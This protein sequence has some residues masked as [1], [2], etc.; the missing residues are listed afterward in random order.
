MTSAAPQ[1][2]SS[3]QSIF[4]GRRRIFTGEIYE[5]HTFLAGLGDDADKERERLR[6]ERIEEL[7]SSDTRGLRKIST[8]SGAD[9]D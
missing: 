5:D 9:L 4:T 3:A 8:V 7:R 2:A 1:Q 6:Q